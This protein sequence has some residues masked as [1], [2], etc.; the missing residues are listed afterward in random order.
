MLLQTSG[1]VLDLEEPF[2][3]LNISPTGTTTALV[4]AG[5]LPTATSRPESTSIDTM[6]VI[7]Q[8]A[9]QP[10]DT[11]ASPHAGGYRHNGNWV[12]DD[13]FLL[14]ARPSQSTPTLRN[15]IDQK[16]RKYRKSMSVRLSAKKDLTAAE[17][18]PVSKVLLMDDALSFFLSRSQSI[19][20]A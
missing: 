16:V 7:S 6:S 20:A 10:L 5:S 14:E 1:R 11:P 17:I 18:C 3:A 13:T 8:P 2:P 15:R 12:T 19:S 9:C 4:D